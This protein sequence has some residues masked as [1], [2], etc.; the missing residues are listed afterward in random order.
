LPGFSVHADRAF[1]SAAII[2][3]KPHVARFHT[4]R[5][6]LH[7][8]GLE[9]AQ[10]KY[11]PSGRRGRDPLPMTPGYRLADLKPVDTVIGV[12]KYAKLD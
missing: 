6:V 4:T 1:R 10:G 7:G 12:K 11:P 5:P 2:Q 3:G 8:N 9:A